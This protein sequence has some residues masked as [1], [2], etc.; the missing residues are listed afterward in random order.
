MSTSRFAKL[1]GDER[2][3]SGCRAAAGSA[4]KLGRVDDGELRDVRRELLA[5][6]RR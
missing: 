2:L 3:R 4:L 1:S 6:G 5:V